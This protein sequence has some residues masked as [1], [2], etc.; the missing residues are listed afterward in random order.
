MSGI[1]MVF[2]I[3]GAVIVF[4]PP[5]VIIIRLL[6][7]AAD[8]SDPARSRAVLLRLMLIAALVT[9]VASAFTAA[10]VAG[11]GEK[12][13]A[14][15]D[16][17]AELF[18]AAFMGLFILIPAYILRGFLMW[19]SMR[20]SNFVW[21]VIGGSLG[22]VSLPAWVFYTMA[23]GYLTTSEMDAQDPVAVVMAAIIAVP[24]SFL[25]ALLGEA[26]AIVV[27]TIR[28]TWERRQNRRR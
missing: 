1:V 14:V 11:S 19:V 17:V 25:G 5:V 7:K 16:A 10:V 9:P 6:H 4:G 23:Y 13:I 24:L 21:A 12:G 3:C 27:R 26:F 2:L 28:Q 22:L 18:R 15:G 20:R 8:E